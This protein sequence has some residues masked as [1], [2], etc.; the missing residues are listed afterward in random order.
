MLFFGIFSLVSWSMKCSCMAPLT[1]AVMVMTSVF[2]C[3]GFLWEF[4]VT[5]CEFDKLYCV[6]GGGQ[7]SIGVWV[8]LGAPI[9]HIMSGLSL[10]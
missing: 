1:P 5:I 2:V 7:G 10:A 8:W 9:M 3:E 6:V 4:V